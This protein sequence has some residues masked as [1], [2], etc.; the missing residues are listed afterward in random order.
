MGSIVSG[1]MSNG[2]QSFME[3]AF[4]TAEVSKHGALLTEKVTNLN[5]LCGEAADA[6]EQH[7]KFVAFSQR[8]FDE[9]AK[10]INRSQKVVVHK[11]KSLQSL[12][13]LDNDAFLKPDVAETLRHALLAG[14]RMLRAMKEQEEYGAI[15]ERELAKIIALNVRIGNVGKGPKA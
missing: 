7:M 11:L 1:I 6:I 12:G 14:K 5:Q 8:A 15:L 10:T 3:L 9:M 13:K 4:I 2:K